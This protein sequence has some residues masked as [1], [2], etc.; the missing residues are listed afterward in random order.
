[1][2]EAIREVIKFEIRIPCKCIMINRMT[3][4][5]RENGLYDIAR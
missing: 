5:I 3:V 4:R 2:A 1:M